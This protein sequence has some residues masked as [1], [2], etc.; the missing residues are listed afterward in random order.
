MHV[1][2]TGFLLVVLVV[3]SSLALLPL[4]STAQPV[5]TK[6][7]LVRGFVVVRL[8]QSAN[9]AGALV[10]R[11]VYLPAAR[12][13]LR[14]FGAGRDRAS[15]T[16]D[17]SGRFTLYAPG[18]G[19]FEV[20]VVAQGFQDTCRDGGV[21]EQNIVSLK[22]QPHFV[23]RV[24]ATPAKGNTPTAVL[25]GKVSLADGTNPRSFEPFGDINA[26]ATVKL[27]S[28]GGAAFE[29]PVNN[30]GEYV[31]GAV[32]IREDLKLTTTLEGAQ[33]EQV[34]RKETGLSPQGVYD[35]PI[36]LPNRRPTLEPIVA[37]DATGRQ[38]DIARP[39]DK[40]T[41]RLRARDDDGDALNFI[42]VVPE[43]AGTLSSTAD[44][45][46][47]WTL[48]GRNGR[49]QL[50]ALVADGRGG[51]A[52]ES[53][54]MQVTTG[55]VPFS[56]KVID[57]AGAVVAGAQVEVGG[58]FVNSDTKGMFR[59]NVPP[60]SR[61]VLNIRKFGYGLVSKVVDFGL[62]GATHVMSRAQVF[63]VNPTQPITVQ[64]KR[65]SRDCPSP[66]ATRLPWT[67][68]EERF[69]PLLEAS[70]QDGR[71]RT[72]TTDEV[73]RGLRENP[74]RF[75]VTP[76]LG[77]PVRVD[78]KIVESRFR[79]PQECG[80]G[81][82]LRIPANAL[83]DSSGQLPTGNVQIALT[84]VNLASSEQ[85]PGDYTAVDRNGQLR[86]ME[87]YGAG[88]VEVVSGN[89]RY[90]LKPGATAEFGIP[91]D[92]LQRQASL[93]P[94]ARI[95]ILFYDE[96]TGFWREEGSATLNGSNYIARIKHF[97]AINADHTK[98]AQSCVAIDS[99]AIPGVTKLEY[100]LPPL[101][102]GA[103]PI[104]RTYTFESGAGTE[105]V[106]YNLPSGVNITL[107]PIIN[108]VT[109]TGDPGEVPAG[110]F[111]VNTSG[112]Q[113]PTN[114]NRPVGPP[115]YTEDAGG[116]PLGPC[117]VKVT[118][119]NLA[120]P[121]APDAPDEFLQG[122]NFS[123][124]NLDEIGTPGTGLR[125]AVE[126]GSVNYYNQA[127]PRGLRQD[128]TSFK[129]KNGFNDP[130]AVIVNA[131]FANSGDLGFGRNMNCTKRTADDGGQDVACYV[132]NYG[133]ITTPDQQDADNAHTN[134]GPIAT[135]AME[136]SRVE[137]P[138]TD[139]LEFPDNNRIVKFYVYKEAL[140]SPVNTGQGN[141]RA[142]SA[143]LDGTGERPVPQLCVVCH[144]GV[145]AQ[146]P[147]DPLDPASPVRPAFSFRDDVMNMG[148]RFL[149]FDLHYYTFPAARDQAA[150]EASIRS[151]NR[152]YVTLAP[153]P[154]DPVNDAVTELIT[155]FYPTPASNQ[156]ENAVVPNWNGN[157]ADRD[158][159]TRVLARA[160]RTCH[161]SSPFG[162]IDL[163]ERTEFSNNISSVQ[164]RVCDQH[165]MPHAKRTHDLFWTSVNPNQAGLLQLFGQGF[166]GWNPTTAN[167]QC[168]LTP[169]I[170][171]GT[172]TTSFYQANIQPIFDNPV[173]GPCSSC[174]A[175]AGGSGNLS[176]N[177]SNAYANLVGVASSALPSMAR[178]TAGNHNNSYLW[179]KIN[180]SHVTIAGG[181][182]GA[183]RM[184]PGGASLTT[185]DTDGD[186]TNDLLEIQNWIDGGA[187]GP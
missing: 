47:T 166:P 8:R 91:V 170:S 92:P 36:R 25:H 98:T 3:V 118:M 6:P 171:G 144:S 14:D 84:T 149:P 104:N 167:A 34:V 59:L 60:A 180:G 24:F 153:A 99:S 43:G 72:L 67:K 20:C 122:L 96:K 163:R 168:G 74:K 16:T 27:E 39:G 57:N 143:D 10:A 100:T 128:L 18:P 61:Y 184:P 113:N 79:V 182:N 160:C 147:T 64:H 141:G 86:V 63:T 58:R 37:Q 68:Q 159:Y 138:S 11:D 21:A 109:V 116:N 55:G 77:V 108:G 126:Q 30:H 186:G 165:V 48:P 97:S 117:S 183:G 15:A 4:R 42:W 56:G 65:G 66:S 174:H 123:A 89:R 136:Y 175:V 94:S 162:N 19:R 93:A 112:P 33:H 52:R 88:T 137:N 75:E 130:G 80:P 135:V 142:I 179:H 87:S 13:F 110:V 173:N 46:V 131:T 119:T 53:F 158:F 133:D 73:R 181:P 83:V 107:I 45:T 51:Y 54:A 31:F 134:T 146:E 50:S 169:L 49:Y 114:P 120:V 101:S 139:P 140:P 78:G 82:S 148:S 176:L 124:T 115:Y 44:P 152:D 28:D 41:L 185:R 154:A 156:N 5:A 71:G 29:T 69:A 95:P 105:H 2:A 132:T 127:D 187:A 32:P 62:N 178:V 150:Q 70:F 35:L 22:D 129:Q 177:F 26:F 81:V 12:V 172:I 164:T 85:M 102:A 40:L 157:A 125:T 9:V 161:V 17:L 151:L 23:S 121:G 155:A 7:V 76:P 111:V 103:A 38:A 90:N 1:R 106:L 145:F